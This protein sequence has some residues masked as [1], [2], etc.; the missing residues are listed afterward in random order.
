MQMAIVFMG[1]SFAAIGFDLVRIL[2]KD[3]DIL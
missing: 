2:V 1:S 3:D